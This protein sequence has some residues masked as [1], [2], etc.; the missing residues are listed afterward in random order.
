MYPLA[1]GYCS[2]GYVEEVAEGA[3]GFSVG[4]RVIAMGWGYAIHAEQIAVP[5]KLCVKLPKSLS[6]EHAV[7]ANMSATA[8]HA[9]HRARLEGNERVLVIGAGLVG[10]MVMQ[11][12]RMQVQEVVA[13]D[14]SHNRLKI[15]EAS[16]ITCIY[17][18][19]TN[20][21][22]S[23][24]AMEHSQGRGFDTVFLCS[25]GNATEL[26][27]QCLQL[28]NRYRDGHKR[29]TIVVVGRLEAHLQ[30]NVD[31]GNV[32]IRYSARCGAGYRDEEYVHGRVTYEAP[33]GEGT[34]DRNLAE[35]VDAIHQGRLDPSLWH[36]HR[37]PVREATQ[38]YEL[39]KD[40][41]QALGVTLH[42]ED[43][44]EERVDFAK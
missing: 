39:L 8:L 10:Q 7:F 40:P 38:A 22:L 16:G 44:G 6:F 27:N 37:F 34:V 5:Y 23:Q 13:S 20:K 26:F 31:L 43:Q 36:T 24:Q 11:W 28:M 21:L 35:S 18:D 29:G 25:S 41:E 17:P 4:D 19:P 1:L 42:Y 14:L 32:D 12:A 3:H 30:L 33:S 9:V 2:S 15:A